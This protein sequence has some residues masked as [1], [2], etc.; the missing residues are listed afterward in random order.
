MIILNFHVLLA[1]YLILL[2]MVRTGFELLQIFKVFTNFL[3]VLVILI[4]AL[5]IRVISSMDHFGLRLHVTIIAR[6]VSLST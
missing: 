5:E 3:K 6:S 1:K 2:E 4:A